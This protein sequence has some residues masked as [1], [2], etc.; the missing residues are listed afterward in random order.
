MKNQLFLLLLISS[1]VA[2]AQKQPNIVWIVCEDMSPHLGSYGEKVAKTPNLDQLA[3]ESVRFTNVFSTAGV[4]APSRAALISGCYQTAIG[5]QHMRTMGPNPSYYN[6]KDFPKGHKPYSA[7][8]PEGVIGFPEYL[9]KV[10]YYCT[11]NAK[12]DYQFEAPVTMW[13]ESST[14]AHWRNRKD[15]NQPFF[16]V[17]NFEVTH[18]MQVWAREKQA[19]LVNPNEIVVPP[20]Y[21]NDSIAKVTMARFLSNVMVMDQQIGKI[22]EQLKEDGLYENTILF[23]YSDHGDGMP[24]VKREVLQRGMRVPLLVKAPFLKAGSTDNRLISFID[25]GPSILSLAGIKVPKVMHGIDFLGN[26]QA[27]I[28]RKYV[29]GA[30]D[31]M[32][33]QV[34]RVRS[35]S[36]GR[37][38]YIRNYYPNQPSYQNIDF[39]LANPLMKHMIEL[40]DSGKLN[41]IQM[42]W[43]KSP[44]NKEELYDFKND[45]HEIN[46][47]ANNPSYK[48]HLI[49]LRKQH[50]KW[51]QTYPDLSAISEMDM[52]NK[53]WKGKDHAPNTEKVI[54]KFTNG[55]IHLSCPTK[56]ASIAYKKHEKD[57]WE[58]Y[59]K[60][61]KVATGDSLY[62]FSQRIGYQKNIQKILF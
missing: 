1:I 32:D 50:E 16:S 21:P 48:K 15:K 19:L 62:L 5:G 31:R 13:N 47:L 11:N 34:D 24:F 51:L 42:Q 22:I 20:Y 57:P 29:F 3:K 25:F 54:I 10:G 39:R 53:W 58:V 27:K 59:I 43:F 41:T 40:K 6:P 55:Q 45:P 33:S 28:A 4:C 37:F 61:F 49:E 14:N 18:E 56:S 2:H 30:R 46:D 8:L 36:D 12:Q 9:R 52:V 35:V 38:T 17:F 26:Q 60:P 44:R 23:F 7:V